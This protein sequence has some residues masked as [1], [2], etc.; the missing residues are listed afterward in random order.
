MSPLSSNVSQTAATWATLKFNVGKTG[1]PPGCNN[2]DEYGGPAADGGGGGGP[3]PGGEALLEARAA[4]AAKGECIMPA[5]VV[6]EAGGEAEFEP[7]LT[8]GL[9]IGLPPPDDSLQA[10]SSSAVGGGEGL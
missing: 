6:T 5:L 9:L 1:K 10:A 4:T 8:S 3:T 2:N 7:G